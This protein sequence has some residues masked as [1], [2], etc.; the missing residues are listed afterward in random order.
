MGHV[1]QDVFL[2]DD[3]IA[4]NVAFGAAADGPDGLDEAAVAGALSAAGLDGLVA[5]L[6]DGADT[7]VGE[8]GVR[9]SGGE[10]QRIAIARALYR[11]PEL[12]VLDEATSALDTVT[13][14]AVLRAVL[15]AAR[16]RT[17]V[18]V[19]HRLGTVRSCDTVVLLDGGRVADRGSYD[20][21]LARNARFRRMHEARP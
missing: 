2:S 12:I 17:V 19:A 3:S 14:R 16:D 11:D 6:P 7:A 10:R 18:M 1:P 5:S 8:R 21:L 20:A 15:G 4:R 9:L 13:E